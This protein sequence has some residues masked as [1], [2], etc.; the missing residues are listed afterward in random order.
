MFFPYGV[1]DDWLSGK[2]IYY[3]WF[4]FIYENS[5]TLFVA[6][7]TW[8]NNPF[9]NKLFLSF[10]FI[11]ILE[12]MDGDELCDVSIEVNKLTDDDP[13]DDR[14]WGCMPL[15]ALVGIMF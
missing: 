5:K 7:W 3:T 12:I 8:C 4:F 11:E 13:S 14:K 1:I 9:A 6:I 15:K 2:I 10:I